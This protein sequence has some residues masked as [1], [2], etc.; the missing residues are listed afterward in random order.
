MRIFLSFASEQKDAAEPILLALRNRGHKVFFSD[1]DLPRGSS[2]DSRIERAIA[3]SDL[4]I[5]L[6]SPQSVT[7]G[8][9]TLTELAFARDRWPSPSGRVLPVVVAPT[10]MEQVPHYLRAVS[11]LEPEGN[12]AAETAAAVDKLQAG[13]STRPMLLFAGLGLVTG[14]LTYLTIQFAPKFL[15]FSFVITPQQYGPNPVTIVPGVIFG[16]LVAACIYWHGIVDRFLL[17]IVL[18][19]TTL[20]WIAA[21]DATVT[22]N[23]SLGEFKKTVSEVKPPASPPA[24]GQEVEDDPVIR[25]PPTPSTVQMPMMFAV[26][27]M[28]G[29]LVGG[30]ITIFGVSIAAPGFRRVE[31][32]VFTLAVAIVF[33]AL[34]ELGALGT[35]GFLALFAAWQSAVIAMIARGLAAAGRSA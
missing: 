29:G 28:V 20:A 17:S 32:W 14:L 1:D 22:A 27:G 23:L 2:F 25:L 10:P 9:Y 24:T 30:L 8:R 31:S 4:L 3:E 18:A 34:L 16:S 35:L 6:V 19:A 13:A 26:S 15:T 21:Y 5:F 7:K 11:L 12:L 33:G